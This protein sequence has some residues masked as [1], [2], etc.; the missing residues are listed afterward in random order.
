MHVETVEQWR[1][2]LAEHHRSERSVWL[3]TWRSSTGRPAPAYDQQVE[4]ALCVGWIDSTRVRIDEER[5]ML[6]FA[7]RRPGSTWAPSNKERIAR[8]EAAGRL[9]P[10]GRAV[11]ERARA[12]GS[13]TMLDDVEHLVVPDDLA[14]ALDGHGARDRWETLSTSERKQLL[15]W[16]VSAKRATTRSTRVAAAAERAAHGGPPPPAT[17]GT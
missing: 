15:W 3:V 16:I 12:D 17:V 10:A 7:Q 4:E 8:L 1:A 14:E 13:W 2:W 11:V 5:T 6:Y 9:Q